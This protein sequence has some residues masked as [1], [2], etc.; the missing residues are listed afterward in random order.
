MALETACAD[1]DYTVI[2]HLRDL[3]HSL[4]DLSSPLP[5]FTAPETQTSLSSALKD[6]EVEGSAEGRHTVLLAASLIPPDAH[7][8]EAAWLWAVH[9][10]TPASAGGE[11]EA[12][13]AA[14][15][16]RRANVSEVSDSTDSGAGRRNLCAGGEEEERIAQWIA[17][18]LREKVFI[19][20]DRWLLE[21]L[22]RYRKGDRCRRVLIRW[23]VGDLT[24]RVFSYKIMPSRVGIDEKLAKSMLCVRTL[25]PAS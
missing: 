22:G 14:G 16:R 3:P 13:R 25:D 15:E 4:L 19:Q 2:S 1:T 18:A 21:G 23:G 6:L 5:D 24:V 12:G 10:A 9:D 7:W 11:A 17:D 8:E 20:G